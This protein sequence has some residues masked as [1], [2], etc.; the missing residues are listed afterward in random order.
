MDKSEFLEI[1]DTQYRRDLIEPSVQREAI[2]PD[3]PR[4]VRHYSRQFENGFISYSK[5]DASN[6]EAEIDA[7]VAFFSNLGYTFE[8]K[9]YDHDRPS[10]LRDRLARRG[11][12]I[13][14]PEALMI[15]DM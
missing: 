11:F 15:L 2:P 7:Q 10:D 6:V 3:E 5:L 8:W 12:T 14:D 13:D 1:F 4:V 9:V